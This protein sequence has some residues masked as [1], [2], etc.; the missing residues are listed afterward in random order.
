MG[1]RE[2]L[3][4]LLIRHHRARGRD[5]EALD[6][7]DADVHQ[8]GAAL[9]RALVRV[10]RAHDGHVLRLGGADLHVLRELDG[11]SGRRVDGLELAAVLRAGLRV[12]RI[13]LRGAA[14]HP[15]HDHG[16]RRAAR[17]LFRLRLLGQ[18]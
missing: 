9:V 18:E 12:P 6:G 13:D 15:Q 17:R 14:A 2:V 10:H 3:A 4:A 16:L 1:Q 8:G 11:G 7:V 5:L